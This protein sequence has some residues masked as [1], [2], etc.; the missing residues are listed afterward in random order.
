MLK[1]RKAH[2][3]PFLLICFI[4]LFLAIIL[5]SKY[6]SFWEGLIVEQKVVST[7]ADCGN[8]QQSFLMDTFPCLLH[9]C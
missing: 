3:F 4:Y 7:H 8:T 6:T 1:I 2:F 5:T 9:T